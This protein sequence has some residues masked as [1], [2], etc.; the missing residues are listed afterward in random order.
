MVKQ[1]V[2]GSGPRA[3]TDQYSKAVKAFTEEL[4]KIGEPI[5]LL[6]VIG[7][8]NQQYN[9]ARYTPFEVDMVSDI[10]TTCT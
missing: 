4:A 5:H 9:E 3:K 8:D 7:P 6:V 1:V 2:F 10:L